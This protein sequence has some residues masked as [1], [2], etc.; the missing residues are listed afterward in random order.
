MKPNPS[1][2]A[3]IT[4]GKR[5]GTEGILPGEFL[6]AALEKECPAYLVSASELKLLRKG[7]LY[8]VFKLA[9]D[10]SSSEFIARL[11]GFVKLDPNDRGE[12]SP[13]CMA[14]SNYHP[15]VAQ[16]LVHHGAPVDDRVLRDPVDPR[17]NTLPRKG[18]TPLMMAVEFRNPV[19][20]HDFLEA[21]AN[22][23]LVDAHGMDALKLALRY[24][25]WLVLA[26]LAPRFSK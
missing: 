14:A 12:T 25:H 24:P 21:G 9:C 2:R 23:H 15:G 4:L 18:R 13:I 1:A 6:K 7:D 16:L 8:Y 19:A 3:L 22:P 17:G 20:V 11:L 10:R 26:I 5:F